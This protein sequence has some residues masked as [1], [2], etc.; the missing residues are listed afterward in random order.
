MYLV[1]SQWIRTR[2]KCELFR[3][4][5]SLASGARKQSSVD[6]IANVDFSE[7]LKAAT[8]QVNNAQQAADKLS[9]QF[10]SERSPIWIC[11]R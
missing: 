11:M 3:D 4:N 1:N 2:G 9:M 10:V 5:S 8:D 7:K 6:E